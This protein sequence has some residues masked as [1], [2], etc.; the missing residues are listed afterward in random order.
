MSFASRAMAIVS[1]AFVLLSPVA[2][3]AAVQFSLLELYR[4]EIAR[5]VE[6]PGTS[7]SVAAGRINPASWPVQGRGGFYLSF[8]DFE[9]DRSVDDITGVLS[10]GALGFGVRHVD[11]GPFRWTDYTLGLGFGNRSAAM[12]IAYAWSKGDREELGDTERLISGSLYRWSWGSLGLMGAYDF[13]AKQALDQ[14]D[15]GLRPFGPRWTL[16]GDF[17]GWRASGKVLPWS[18]YDETTWG[19]GVQAHV[20][21]GLAVGVRAD[22]EGNIG[23]RLDLAWD[24]LRPSV[25]NRVNDDGD[26]VSTTY[27]IEIGEGP[28]LRDLLPT[29]RR[30]PEID[31]RGP[32]AYQ[33]YR[34]FD[35][36]TRFLELLAR[37]H[38]YAE[39]P[40]IEGVLLNLS[41]VQ[42]NAANAWELR[43]QLAGLRAVGKKVLV[44]C[45]RLG[46]SDYMLASVADELWMDPQGSLD[47]TGLNTGRSYYRRMLEKAGI[48]F[49]EWRFFRYKSAAESFSRE[50]FSEGDR[51][52][53]EAIL[54]SYWDTTRAIITQARG[55]DLDAYERIVNEKGMILATEAE[56]LGLVD[57]VGDFHELRAN[58]REA[59]RR[60]GPDADVAAMGPMFGDPVWRGE[61]WGEAPRIAVLYAIGP[62]EMDS[63]IRGRELSKLIRRMR[64]DPTVKA[65]VL[66]ADSP[67]GDPLPSDLVAREL[68]ETSAKKPVIV[69]QGQVAGSG[70]YWISMD[71]DRIL[72]SPYTITGSIGVIG[73]HVY[74]AGIADRWGI[75]YDHVQKGDSAD[76]Y[77]GP[78]LPLVGVSIP[79][80]PLRAEER[81]RVKEWFDE[82]YSD[83]VRAVAE[84]RSLDEAKVREIG[85]GRIWSGTDGARIGLVDEIAG[86]WHAIILAKQAA[87]LPEDARIEIVE[88]PQPGLIPPGLLSPRLI[89]ARLAAAWK[90]DGPLRTLVSEAPDA[91]VEAVDVRPD[92]LAAVLTGEQWLALPL[93]TRAYL[94][95][96]FTRPGRPA[97]LVDPID[98]GEWGSDER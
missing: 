80:R 88:G 85:E 38:A 47:L 92:P 49:D 9:N 21:P 31:L 53:R 65:I 81:A 75:D 73:A 39:D 48:G 44:Y 19:Y 26:R 52:Q 87:G 56:R 2:A 83:F 86:L 67:G 74:D 89:G 40:Q 78:S 59:A 93:T 72:A 4:E 76:L 55:I 54:D 10:L 63:G 64:E 16:F 34:W 8:E 36:R 33:R 71:G 3:S 1:S 91:R 27:A 43:A 45:D 97:L 57:T 62:C 6:A 30:Y 28:N 24:S 37:I 84:G 20:L 13:A 22:D 77:G 69:S 82:L 17:L 18:N 51:E 61:E 98:F 11:T 32:V 96:V 90:Q 46:M 29:G 41:G 68:R 94:H 70:G 50:S 79:H 23:L 14:I 25:R 66:R 42:M 60:P 95:H 5:L 58:V 7:R 15:V 35:D 12:G